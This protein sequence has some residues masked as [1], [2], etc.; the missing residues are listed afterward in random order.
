[1]LTP[2]LDHAT[3]VLGAALALGL[4]Y[5]AFRF[6]G[7]RGLLAAIGA[8]GLLFIY[9]KG[10]AD[11]STTHIEKERADAD[12]AVREADDARADARVRDADP[13]RLRDD[14]GYRRD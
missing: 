6:G 5:A 1:M 14:D 2:L 8:L 10:R 3:F 7:L 12:H 9:R 13:E 4:L 11:G